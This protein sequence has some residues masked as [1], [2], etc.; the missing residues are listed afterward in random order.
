MDAFLSPPCTPF[1]CVLYPAPQGHVLFE[2]SVVAAQLSTAGVPADH[3]VNDWMSWDTVGR[4][5][6]RRKGPLVV[7]VGWQF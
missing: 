7:T 6:G 3:I 2:S 1:P 4:I 5:D